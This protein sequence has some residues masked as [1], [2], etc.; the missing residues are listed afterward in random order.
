MIAIQTKY[1]PA[2][3]TRGSRIKAWVSGRS[4]SVSIPYPHDLS[5]ELAYF[6]AVKEYVKKFG[7]TAISTDD[8][9]YGSIDNGYV[10][11]FAD[12]IVGK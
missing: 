11:C 2:T 6:A 9:R 8:M 10:F 5:H 1:V 4:G 3:D 7:I 12:S